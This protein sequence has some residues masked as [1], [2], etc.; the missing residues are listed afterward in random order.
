MISKISINQDRSIEDLINEFEKTFITQE[1][2]IK[3]EK[4]D[5]IISDIFYEE[6]EINIIVINF[7]SKDKCYS[8]CCDKKIFVISKTILHDFFIQI[9]SDNKQI[10]NQIKNKKEE[11]YMC[12]NKTREEFNND[13]FNIFCTNLKSNS[14][15]DEQFEEEIKNL[16]SHF[17]IKSKNIKEH[18]LFIQ[19]IAGYIIKCSY[20][21]TKLET[22]K[23]IEY[24]NKEAN[25]KEAN[26]KRI[27]DL[28]MLRQIEFNEYKIVNLCLNIQD[29]LLYIT[30]TFNNERFYQTEKNIFEIL[31]K[32]HPYRC[33]FQGSIEK[34]KM[35]ILVFEYYEGTTLMNIENMTLNQLDKIIIIFE[36]MTCIEE[37]HFEGII[38]RD[39]NP[40]NIIID[41][42]KRAILN[43]FDYSRV[44]I[45][46]DEDVTSEMTSNIGVEFYTS[47]EQYSNNKYFK[48]TDIY[49]LGRIM[50]F[51]LID[52]NN[53][54]DEYQHPDEHRIFEHI[55]EMC[56][57]F[58]PFQR[59]NISKLINI[60]YHEIIKHFKTTHFYDDKDKEQ[61]ENTLRTIYKL[62][63]REIEKYFENESKE[64][65][66]QHI[67]EILDIFEYLTY[68]NYD[69]QKETLKDM[70]SK[71]QEIIGMDENLLSAETLNF[72]GKL[73]NEG[74]YLQH[75]PDKS[76]E[77]FKRSSNNGCSEAQYN[78]GKIYFLKRDIK[79]AIEYYSESAK[80]NNAK[81][82]YHLGI[83]YKEGTEFYKNEE[84]WIEYFTQSAKQNHSKSRIELIKYF[85][86]KQDI[87]GKLQQKYD[88]EYLTNIYK[89]FKF[90]YF[91][92]MKMIESKNNEM[93]PF[94]MIDI[95]YYANDK[96]IVIICS[97]KHCYLI[98]TNKTP[99]E[100]IKFIEGLEL[101]YDIKFYTTND[102]YSKFFDNENKF[103]EINTETTQLFKYFQDKHSI[104][105]DFYFDNIEEYFINLTMKA[106]IGFTLRKFYFH[107][108]EFEDKEL[109]SL[110]NEKRREFEKDE[111]VNLR[112]LGQGSF[113]V[114]SLCYHLKTCRLYAIKEYLNRNEYNK[115]FQ[116]EKEFYENSNNEF[117]VK[118]YGTISK[119]NAFVI[120]YMSHGSLTPEYVSSIT[121]TQRMKLI[122]SI[123]T[124]IKYLHSINF[125][126][127]DLKPMNIFINH[128]EDF[129]VG[130][131]S[132]A[133]HIKENE[134]EDNN[135]KDLGTYSY[136]SHNKRMTNAEKD[137]F[138]ISKIMEE[139]IF[140]SYSEFNHK[141][142]I[143]PQFRIYQAE[144][145]EF[146]QHCSEHDQSNEYIIIMIFYLFEIFISYK[147]QNFC[148][149]FLKS[150]RQ[151][152]SHFIH[153]EN[154]E[155]NNKSDFEAIIVDLEYLSQNTS[156]KYE[157]LKYIYLILGD[158]FYKGKFI[159]QDIS[160]SIHYFKLSS[161]L[162]SS[163]AQYNLGILYYEGKYVSRDIHKSIHYMT[164]SANQNNSEAQYNLGIIYSMGD[165]IEKDINKSI[166]YLTLSANQNNSEAQY[167]LGI[168]YLGGKYF[169]RDIKKSI[170][171][172]TLAADNNDPM[173]QY[174]IGMIYIN[175]KYIDQD[176]NKSIHYLTL[177]ANQ[178]N[179]SAQFIL[180]V[181][182][183]EG[184]YIK[185]DIKKSIYYLTLSANQNNVDAQYYL[186]NIYQDIRYS[187]FD[188]NKSIY[189]LTLAAK[190]NDPYAQCN[191]GIM[192]YDGQYIL[193]NINKSIY[194]LTLS[195]N[196]NNSNAQYR[197]GLIYY[198]GKYISS[199]IKKSLY[200][201][202]LSADQNNSDAQLLLGIIYYNNKY[203]Q[204]DISKSIHYLT[205]SANQNN[206][207]AFFTLGIIYYEGK[208]VSRDINKA[209]HYL[210]L[211]SD[212]N[213][214]KAQ[215]LLGTI[216]YEE[217]YITRDINKA[218]HY[219]ILSSNQNNQLAQFVLGKIYYE[220]KYIKS[221]INKS[222]HFFTLAANENNQ[223]AQ[224]QLGKIYYENNNIPSDITKAIHY[225]TLAS[226]QENE[227]AQLLLGKIYY[228][229]KYI[230]SDINKAIHYFSLSSNNN[231][232]DAQF[233]LGRIYLENKYTQ[234]DYIKSFHYL[235]LAAKQNHPHAQYL[236]GILYYNGKYVPRDVNKSIDYLT[237]SSNQNNL[238]ALYKLG[239]IYYEGE[240]I[241]QDIQKSIHYFTLAAN[242]NHILSQVRLGMIYYLREKIPRDIN[243]SI[244]F[245]THAANQNDPFAQYNLGMIYLL[246]KSNQDINKAIKYIQYSAKNRFRQAQ[247]ILADFYLEGKY[248]YYDIEQAIRLYKEVSS[249]NNQYAKNNL[250]VIYKTGIGKIGKNI[251]YAKEYLHE[252]IK[253]KD[254]F[255]SMFNLAT[256]LLEEEESES[257]PNEDLEYKKPIKLLAESSDHLFLPSFIL[258]SLVLINKYES[259]NH[260]IIRKELNEH[261]KNHPELIPMIFKFC[262]KIPKYSKTTYFLDFR[263][264]NYVYINRSVK[265]LNEIQKNQ[266]RKQAEHFRRPIEI[267]SFF[268]E[269]FAIKY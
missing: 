217:K 89:Q 120:E 105:Y 224:F 179:S 40:G 47:P 185:R 144:L 162:N 30:K 108:N 241:T 121:S 23:D 206:E 186:G 52:N 12:S 46:N 50:F 118:Y 3:N 41:E 193:K 176:I 196:Q 66:R 249:F 184:K 1:N 268:Y 43:N 70:I 198:D 72:L 247:A 102:K 158:A 83:I 147:D 237:H 161:N 203:V 248:V 149:F 111:F 15:K 267:N 27:E 220:N 244:Y 236:L 86:S 150:Y 14:K 17:N 197:L 187:T 175:N 169:P 216:Y 194:F 19:V 117:I 39:L 51:I 114:V 167:N 91:T 112:R 71:L 210:S 63:R 190:Q 97:Y 234:K 136:S 59:P 61:I 78:L 64:Y 233:F 67:N 55:Y 260:K 37:I 215:Y 142:E 173:A 192:Y 154:N 18:H 200:Y 180:G 231:N 223:F 240:H 262:K 183:Y 87:I 252:A 265:T 152:F 155:H 16:I 101:F 208:Y 33:N 98:E 214:D 139:I 255:V 4:I 191:L 76:I 199:D 56:T 29:Q 123:L 221:D 95:I 256:I 127:R 222:I 99:D 145:T 229:G 230:E 135:T 49:S 232:S 219:L 178:K 211:A 126:H 163:K 36:V 44:L 80:N 73:Y 226:D 204:M 218:I 53:I 151:I 96:T 13:S 148:K 116:R 134:E 85:I 207:M 181:I 81:A 209:I 131:F 266:E 122:V 106:I 109:F 93:K 259:I 225:L 143:I 182:Y 164:L 107:S 24:T 104:I 32:H 84:E 138:S 110:T 140:D 92:D 137:M 26:E 48:E 269:G 156:N 69:N 133:K 243:K 77:Y 68:F 28:I 2:E 5:H 174:I 113:S 189:Y 129:F 128:D 213:N 58:Q 74:K 261:M 246:K 9:N 31:K 245:L 170:Y 238:D 62:R 20:Y 172:L 153:I 251:S 212:L 157:I 115:Y 264:I 8:I 132:C 25:I 65:K 253:Q 202:T 254:D 235:N 82:Q 34:N 100:I 38:F 103:E 165:Y 171:Y 88:D 90:E 54:K 168:I 141:R 7:E 227:F 263:K 130:D 195:A 119:R 166:Y 22:E 60:F 125:Y 146:I 75:D 42:N 258:L 159:E 21:F 160:K 35:R 205:L 10:K 6:H 11:I 45:N 79:K 94:S 242:R 177:S 57:K 124:G 239:L 201:L 228:E 250:G 257:E 188:I